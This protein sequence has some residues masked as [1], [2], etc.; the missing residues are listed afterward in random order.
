MY[1][2]CCLEEAFLL[3]YAGMMILSHS[4]CLANNSPSFRLPGYHE[5]SSI[6]KSLMKEQSNLE[7]GWLFNNV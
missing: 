1:D 3:T 5:M 4:Y 6:P 2:A 7:I